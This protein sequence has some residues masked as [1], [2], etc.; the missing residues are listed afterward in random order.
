MHCQVQVCLCQP[1]A[2]LG[3]FSLRDILSTLQWIITRWCRLC[4]R[5]NTLTTLL[6]EWHLTGSAGSKINLT[7]IHID[8]EYSD[9]CG[10]ENCA[11]LVDMKPVPGACTHVGILG[12]RY[13][14]SSLPDP[15]ISCK[16][17][18][19]FESDWNNYGYKGVNKFLTKGSHK[20]INHFNFAGQASKCFPL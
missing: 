3:I 11:I 14:S 12:Q 7:F 10:Y 19:I 6:Q 4:I 20:K 15:I 16:L 1:L 8:V 18:V 13:C 9:F 17:D 5:L 2:G